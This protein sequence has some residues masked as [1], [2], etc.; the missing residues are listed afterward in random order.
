MVELILYTKLH[1]DASD[2]IQPNKQSQQN[3]PQ[4]H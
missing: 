4:H 2:E 3:E 1:P